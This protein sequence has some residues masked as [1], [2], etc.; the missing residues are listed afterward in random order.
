MIDLHTHTIYSDGTDT[1]VEILQKAEK[2]GLKCLSITDH[3][4]CGAYEEIDNMDVS[5]Y[6]SGKI[7]RGCELF[8]TIDKGVIELLGYN[9]DTDLLNKVLPQKYKYSFRDISKYE[10]KKSIDICKKLRSYY[11]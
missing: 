2:I 9:V 10:M 8:T 3:S 5:K 7:I 11:R 6:Y 1:V 4:S